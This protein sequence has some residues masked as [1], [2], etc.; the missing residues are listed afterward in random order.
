MSNI[1]EQLSELA[2]EQRQEIL[3]RLLREKARRFALSFA[4]QRLWVLNQM[5]GSSAAYNVPAALWLRGGLR[6]ALDVKAF[7][8]SFGEVIRRHESLRATF[9][10]N[11]ETGQPEQLVHPWKPFHLEIR[12]LTSIAKAEREQA[13][14]RLANQEAQQPFDLA[15]GPVL[16]ARLLKLEAQEYVLLLTLHHIVSDMWSTGI[17]TRELTALYEA[18]SQGQESPLTELPI[19]YADFAHWQR[20]RM[21]G[22]LLEQQ[23]AYWRK[24]LRGPRAVLELPTLGPR[25][26]TYSTRG[27]ERV[28]RLERELLDA[29]KSL[30]QR[31]GVTLFMT[32]IAAFKVLLYRY[33]DQTD[34]IVGTPI[35][36]RNRSEIE[37]LIGLLINTLVLRTDLS[38]EPS[39][40]QLLA[41]VKEIS[42]EAYANQDVPFEKLVEELHPERD[43]SRSPLFQVMF[44]LQNVPQQEAQTQQLSIA[45]FPLELVTAKF[46]LTVPM[47]E[48][49]EGLIGTWEYNTDLFDEQMIEQ[50]IRHYENIL[51]SVI[52]NPDQPISHIPI[53]SE[54]ERRQLLA[55]STHVSKSSWRA[56]S[57]HELFEARVESTP[58][59]VALVFEGSRLT[60]EELN[61]RANKLAN[62][63]RSRGVGPDVLVG[64]SVERSV[65]MVVGLLAI[66]KAGGAYVPLD[67]A[68][69]QQRLAFVLEDAGITVLL[70]RQDMLDI[71]PQTNVQTICLDRDWESIDREDQHNLPHHTEG[72]NLAYVIYTSGS[73]GKPKGV[74]V[75]HANVVRLF[76]ATEPWFHFD[77]RDVWTFFHSYAFD[78]SVWELW[79]ALLKGGQ[80]VLVPYLVSRSPQAFY[81]L[82]CA[83]K[84]T[85]LNQTPSA[86][87]QLMQVDEA[88]A[89]SERLALRLVI[90]GGEA[91]D[92]QSLS[93][94][95]E[96][97]GDETPQLVNMYGIT[98]TTVHVT[99]RP[100]TKA[101]SAKGTGS[102]IGV[103][104]AD[105][106]VYALDKHLELVPFNVAGEMHVGGA[107]VSRGYL[108]RPALTAERFIPNPFS[109]EPGECLYKTGDLARHLSNG[110]LEYL[111]R[112][113]HQV[114]IRGFRIELGEI[115]AA[116]YEHPAVKDA[117]VVAR[118]IGPGEK[119]LAAYL[120]SDQEQSSSV[121]EIRTLLKRRLPDYMVPAA[122]VMLERLP[123][124]ENGKVDRRALP[125]PGEMRP[126]LE[127]AFAPPRTLVEEVLADAWAEVLGLNQVGIDDNFF[128]LGGDSIRSIQVL[129]KTQKRGVSFSLQQLFE[130]QTV[131][132]LAQQLTANDFGSDR[133]LQRRPFAL[134]S[135]EDRGKLPKSVEDAYP[136]TFLQA[137]MLF[138][139]NYDLAADMYHNIGTYHLKAPLDIEIL[140]ETV[141]QLLTRHPVLRTS[142][143]LAGFSEPLQLVHRD[144]AVPLK[145]E[146]ISQLSP[147]EQENALARWEDSEKKRHFDWS[148]APLLR[149]HIHRR[150]E[151]TFQ[152][153]MTEHHAIL[154][155][156]SVASV[157]TELFRNYFARLNGQADGMQS[158][159]ANLFREFVALER[160]A[161]ISEDSQRYWREK[162]S[163]ATITT[164]PRWPTSY[165][166]PAPSENHAVE[167]PISLAVAQ[168]LRQLARSVSVPLKSVLLAAHIR[169]MSFISG[170]S[171][172]VTGLVTHGR[173]EDVDGER[174]LGLFLNTLPARLKVAAG[175]WTNLVREVFE[176]ERE[177]MPFRY[178]PMAQIQR[179][180]GG[181]PLF[182]T[183]FNFT[184]FHVF[185]TLQELDEL[186]VLEAKL[187]AET[188]LT[189]WAN[190]SL[191]L[192]SS[193]IIL[194]L[195]G[196]A[197]SLSEQQVEAIGGY[198]A[199]TLE[200]M[201]HEP[202]ASPSVTPDVNPHVNMVLHSPLSAA[203]R[204]QML[205]EWN[206]GK[207]ERPPENAVS[208]LFEAQVERTP[209]EIAI[210]WADQK[211]TYRELNRRANQLARYLRSL[212]AGPE[213]RVGICTERSIEMVVGLL[214][215]L[216]AGG[217]YVPLDVAYPKDRL[218]FMLEDAQ[219]SA[220]VVQQRLVGALPEHQARIVCLDS[221]WET[222]SREDEKNLPIKVTASNLAY[223]IYTSGSTGKPKGV[224]IEHRSALTFLHWA[225][226][227]FAPADLAGVLA[228]TSICFDLSV[229]ELFAPLSWG[230]KVFLV[231]NALHLST[232]DDD[233]EVTLINTVPSA[234]AE[235]VNLKAVSAPVRTVNLAGEA[236][237][238]KLVQQVYEQGTI[239]QVFNLY[240]PSED[241][242]Y[243]TFAL[244]KRAA[245]E[246]P[247]IGRP[248]AN[249]Q[250]YLLDA[251]QQPV[252][253]GAAGELYIGGEGL[254]RG[255]L[256]R[257]EMTA[258]KFVPDPFG[259]YPGARLY[260]TGDLAR[261]LPDGNLEFLGRIDH[262][263][264]I[265]GFRIEL[266]EIEAALGK[267]PTVREAV[268]LACDDAS[269]DRRLVAYVVANQQS[270]SINELRG[271]LREK[272]PD[273]MV[274]SAFVWLD[275]LPLTPNGKVDRPALR[276]LDNPAPQSERVIT[277]PRDLLEFQL[278][279]IWE[280]LLNKRPISI[281]D[282]FFDLGGH[283]LLA[284]RLVA[285]IKHKLK[286]NLPLSALV[287]SADIENL[288]RILRQQTESEPESL[289]V[290]LQPGGSKQ[291]FFCIHPIGGN[292]LCYMELARCVG[293]DRPFY[294]LQARRLNGQGSSFE[295]IEEMAAYYIDAIRDVQP[296]GPYLLGGWSF[297]GVVAVE[298]ARQLKQRNNQTAHLALF[299]T[300]APATSRKAIKDEFST[301]DLMSRF[302]TDTAGIS[303]KELSVDHELLRQL[304]KQE[305]LRCILEQATRHNILPADMEVAQLALL[306]EIFERNAK[307][308]Q[309]YSPPRLELGSRIILYR[310]SEG[311]NEVPDG[312]DGLTL[313]WDE[314]ILGQLEVRNVSG[315]HYT[316]LASPNARELADQL[317]T[318]LDSLSA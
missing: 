97:H 3:Q 13:A 190:F 280:S 191:D 29:L 107:G 213:V 136:L 175:T 60:Y 222:I 226:T 125:A 193:R 113:D 269:G 297:G 264:K 317:R 98:E 212:G 146:D 63:L 266:G 255:Y 118:D 179:D 301:A 216:K 202:D 142:F 79:G 283:S 172:V 238:N 302:L 158:S 78:F 214:G 308:F 14:R 305:Q 80:L 135:D 34:I 103:P 288:A 49:K 61:R 145:V 38:G 17:L 58:G 188:N 284:V 47:L 115:E 68:Y 271:F 265:R 274:P 148:C 285:Q 28:C 180:Q 141:R 83:A 45:P 312:P 310:A 111:G 184:N 54:K 219:V 133:T 86:F 99:Y 139:S 263:V 90:F 165:R 95:F 237:H 292:I 10:V 101:D 201:A 127:A 187:Y 35:A 276:A 109:E 236:L 253:V 149:F 195:N 162:L 300:W 57:L 27:A 67:P 220:L 224:A 260:R 205:L 18:Y 166:E 20:T 137:G 250:V 37:G 313:G 40:R 114:K 262:Q 279:Q 211:I 116:L 130:Y 72:E 178:Y 112:I 227:V 12:D 31:E 53:L 217:A 296:A 196:D 64:I 126:D 287:Q 55:S 242:T 168:G 41:R 30:S 36:N 197:R 4:Q 16:R 173:P 124:T 50:M 19:Q 140:H 39:F 247:L 82:V 6:G 294:G 261:Y 11:E 208:Q 46:D 91:L 119:Q 164:L 32:L 245:S 22:G 170:Q 204:K 267:H 203:E 102:L 151:T 138:H 215:I 282:N 221:D 157:L 94:W 120:V 76:E 7:E 92:L 69:P 240:G 259:G 132:E 84:V 44:A 26:S 230:G 154:D 8:R 268:V 229:F 62:H 278:T 182:E 93:P 298:I 48:T 270:D 223:V 186:E 273:Y 15:R 156:W 309:A 134:I 252:P 1:T 71:L 104:I 25:P 303:S 56:A 143:D 232:L 306:F 181:Q 295:H 128:E 194:I 293:T 315:D 59:A 88:S 272:L 131:R 290:A 183:V 225:K 304:D 24:Q 108:F 2:A 106:Q 152:F 286:Y 246:E 218:A 51:R 161:L 33:S 42:L 81:E 277:Y 258:E 155:G 206:D 150:S 110:D 147:S 73:T 144:V 256:N 192:H 316:M 5:D 248:I 117:V 251:W 318:Y 89:N 66:L 123:L 23:L 231:E 198:Y 43:M 105:L 249:T 254:A 185:Q 52:A 121:S 228:S 239:Q 233:N 244:M 167:V 65:E 9:E 299:D 171:D 70:T 75:T 307:A 87:R 174:A 163:D 96:R 235:L 291:P 314:F 289:L 153:S 129:T 243:S 74:M 85:V 160:E 169:V 311:K 77:E 159:P 100:L 241:T 210:V 122:F 209:D 234:M 207:A 275:G 200:A 281:K 189:F 21:T 177:L 257:A 199:R 176:A